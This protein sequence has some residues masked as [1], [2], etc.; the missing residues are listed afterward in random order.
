MPSSPVTAACAAY[1]LAIR[2]CTERPRHPPT[3]SPAPPTSPR[4]E[5]LSWAPS[6]TVPAL[7]C[8]HTLSPSLSLFL[9]ALAVHRG[10]PHQIHLRRK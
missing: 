2:L 4:L 1:A 8:W 6:C 10:W 3:T 5:P 9:G 7:I